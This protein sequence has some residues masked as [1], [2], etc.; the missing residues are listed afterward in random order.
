MALPAYEKLG[1]FY[2]GRRVEVES[3]NDTAELIMLD[4][5]ELTTHAVCVGMTG[6]GKTGLCLSLLEEAAIDGVPVI[7]IDPKGDIANLAL[8]FPDLRGADFLPWID[9]GEAQRKGLAPTEL[10]QATAEK[11]RQGLADWQ[12]DGE[13]IRRL[14]SA[15]EVVVYTPGSNAGRSLSVL[16]SFGA[17][18]P[19]LRSDSTAMKERV[20]GAAS[21]LLS[22]LGME[23]DPLQS[24]EH[25]LL[26]T[27]LD[28]SWRKGEDLE[29]AGLIRAI[30]KPPFDRVG[31]LDLETFLP[32]KER[33]R[34]A[35]SINNLLA[36]PGFTAWLEGEPLDPQRMLFTATG[37][38]RIAV[39]SIAHL[40]DAE[41][42][43]IVTLLLNEVVAWMRKQSGTSSLRALLYMDEIFGYFPPSAMPASKLPLLTLMKQARAF[44]LGVVLATQNPVDLDYKGLSNAGTWFIGRLQTERDKARVIDGLLSG[45]AAGME[46]SR[47]EALLANLAPRVFLMRS[48]HDGEPVLMRSRWALSYLRGPMTL[49]EIQRLGQA[50]AEIAT[51]DTQARAD[52]ATV[53]EATLATKTIDRDVPPADANEY[54]ESGAEAATVTYVPSVLGIAKTHFIDRG[55]DV[56]VWQTR[57]LIAPFNDDG[58]APDW[59]AAR[60]RAQGKAG[61]SQHA[62]A[63]ARYAELPAAALRAQSYASWGKELSAALYQSATL[64]VLRCVA[65]KMSSNAEESESEF[66][67]RIALE[68]REQRDSRVDRLRE[69]YATCL[70]T[71]EDQIARGQ[72]R[73]EREHSQ[74]SHQKFQTMLSVGAAVLGA[75]MGRKGVRSKDVSRATTAAR[76]ATRISRESKDVEHAADS[77]QQLQQRFADLQAE[78][79]QEIAQVHSELDP[80]AV[81]LEAVTIKPRK[82]DTVVEEIGMLWQAV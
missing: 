62:H 57:C 1:A 44:G 35:L 40:S 58:S 13:R 27:L 51:T 42:M 55:A 32:L 45:A 26:S 69:R 56:D 76:S 5:R 73:V 65:L 30:Q 10:A 2:L 33:T 6:S 71:L 28:T 8:Q 25:I 49:A 72:Q 37:K 22:L 9:A 15:A 14:Q 17:P 53:A 81:D 24:R 12:Q 46:K 80:S 4:S 82:S 41:R 19:V 31:V 20:A 77:L 7:A 52:R 29:L 70:R 61:L 50:P 36:A 68:L 64:T 54:Y 67:A 34:L 16:R 47:L 43:F 60:I 79:E 38:P 18:D 21:G 74:L 23:V 78:L 59:P 66:R 39:V 63:N 3:G 11:W 48:V 75:F